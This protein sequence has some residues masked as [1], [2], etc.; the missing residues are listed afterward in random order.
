[1]IP[2]VPGLAP[3]CI[4]GDYDIARYLSKSM[5]RSSPLRTASYA[6]GIFLVT[7]Q[8]ARSS[9]QMQAGQLGNLFLTNQAVQIPLT[10]DGSEIRWTVTD[11]F[12]T[13]M[14]S[15]HEVP[16]NRAILIQPFLKTPGYFDLTLTEL[17]NGTETATLTTS[18]GIVTPV[19]IG[20][21][22]D[23]PFGVMTHFAQ[24]NDQSVIPLIARAGIAHIRDEQYWA[25]IEPQKG[26][27]AYPAKFTD[28]MSKAQAASIRPLIPL[29]WSNQNYDWEAG[30]FTAPHSDK[31]R[32][33]YAN[34]ALDV[35]NKYAGQI[36]AVEVWNEYN[37]GTFIKGPAAA[38]KP[39][40]YKLMLQKVYET[41][42]PSH[43]NVKVIAGATVPIAHGFLK[44]LFAQGAIPYL[45]AVSIHAYRSFPDGVDLEI[46]ELRELIKSSNGG[47]D[48][49]IWVTEFSRTNTSSD[50]DRANAAPYVAQIVALMLSQGV[51]RMY[52]YVMID[53]LNFPYFGLVGF[54]SGPLGKFRPHP[55]LI[56]YAN[57]IRQFYKATYRGRFSASPSTYALRFQ[58]R[59]DELTVLWSNHPV[60][61]SLAAS[62][63]LLVTNI[64]GGTSTITPLSGRVSIELS[65]DVQYV[66]GPVT[67]VTEAA[68]DVLADSVSGYSKTAG[69]N[70]W[71]YGFAELSS[72]AAYDPSQFK[73]MT[74]GIWGGDNYRWL[75]SGGY[76]FASG[77]TLH[78]SRYWAIRR[79]V[80]NFAGRAS[81]SGFLSRGSGGDGVGVRIFADGNEVYNHYLSPNQ[82][83]NYS[84][85]D[86][87]LKV[88]SNIDFTVN[89]AAE[90]SFDATTFT[91]MIFH[92]RSA[93][94]P[95][96]A[97]HIHP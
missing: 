53:D 66:R 25:S 17:T 62:S 2:H 39:F 41:I 20:A 43:P 84:V 35:L 7:A 1:M 55:A 10:C 90:S 78:P 60:C 36:E 94:H 15:G 22:S 93:P 50:E 82:S 6:V 45:D 79:W 38:N 18:F 95:P 69:E 44:S 67:S 80:S 83:I 72:A 42:K 46:A 11:Y 59:P 96:R 76:P 4:V 97:P 33:G 8:M 88:G 30:I 32:L 64:M 26:V 29:T 47:I 63:E 40:Y 75:A 91:S 19:D 51:E 86:I 3:Q 34:Y 16:R 49:P 70:G 31:G 57:A 5:T 14:D 23:S 21:M 73:Q 28:Y 27:F 81:L 74:W 61:V 13:T 12:G 89:Q 54:S 87:A 24:Y 71:F 92:Q 85:P 52:Y 58:R 37:A 9:I 77:N 68:N 48:K 56:A 65:K